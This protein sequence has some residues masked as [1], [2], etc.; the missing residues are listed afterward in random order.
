MFKWFPTFRKA[1]QFA[2]N[3]L[4]RPGRALLFLAFFCSLGLVYLESPLLYL[5]TSIVSVLALASLASLFFRPNIK[6]KTIVPDLVQ[7][8]VPLKADF[9]LTNQRQRSAFEVFV[10]IKQDQ[11]SVEFDEE[12]G[13]RLIHVIRPGKTAKE[14]LGFRFPRRGVYPIPTVTIGSTFPFN[15]FRFR[16]A[17][18]SDQKIIVT[19][20]FH[21][22]ENFQLPGSHDIHDLEN[23]KKLQFAD[24]AGASEYVGN[25]EYREGMPVRRW[26]YSSWAR[27]GKPVV[28]EFR[29]QKRGTATVFVDS[30][31]PSE[32][33][34]HQEDFE[35]LLSLATAI[36]DALSK[37]NILVSRLIVGPTIYTL[38]DANLDDQL[39][40][41]G[42]KLAVAEI[43]PEQESA[44][45]RDELFL[46]QAIGQEGY[47]F[48]LFNRFNSGRQYFRDQ[49]ELQGHPCLVRVLRSSTH[50]TISEES[51]P[52][53]V[54]RQQI[55]RGEVDLK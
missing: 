53:V 31:F 25:R 10:E 39:R 30:F 9:Y 54:T 4:T 16:Q 21:P 43:S 34:E 52:H 13:T 8:R 32:S 23:E 36:V 51:Q 46:Q 40:T 20:A 7:A 55:M 5:F 14:S 26:D 15:L 49:F 19:P 45:L 2:R 50:K 1:V 3:N 24:A 44:V 11:E 29:E 28:R 41:I 38:I 47:G 12:E 18:P 33:K 27:T 17:K 42:R 22:L 48:L 6:L 37:K 35:A